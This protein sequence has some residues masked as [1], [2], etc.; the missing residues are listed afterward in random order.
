MISI[1]LFWMIFLCSIRER[2]A[3]GRREEEIRTIQENIS[4]LF[5]SIY[6]IALPFSLSHCHT[7]NN[8]WI[9]T[10]YVL[11]FLIH[12]ERSTQRMALKSKLLGMFSSGGVGNMSSVNKFFFVLFGGTYGAD[13]DTTGEYLHVCSWV[14]VCLCAD[15][16]VCLSVDA[17]VNVCECMC[18]CLLF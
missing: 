10:H 14:R 5:N 8:V 13:G 17:I 9:L 11:L 1:F 18:I 2:P 3:T 12:Q 4:K 16:Y 15:V 6:Y 7:L